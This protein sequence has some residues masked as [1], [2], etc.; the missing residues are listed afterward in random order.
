MINRKNW[1]IFCRV[2]D[3]FG[4][5]GVCW[6][7][8]R[9]LV[10]E[11]QKAVTLWVDDLDSFHAIWPEID[12]T[13]THQACAGVD[14][15]KWGSPLPNIEVMPEVVIEAF[16][17]DLPDNYVSAMRQT[18][19]LWLNLEYL[20][21]EPWVKGCHLNQSP[22]HG[23]RKTFFFPGFEPGTGGLLWDESLMQLDAGLATRAKRLLALAELGAEVDPRHLII[24]LFAYENAAL[25]ALLQALADRPKPTT[26][27]IPAG[28][29]LAGVE[30]WLDASLKPGD[31]I[32][33]GQLTIA[34]LPFLTQIQYD[35]LLAASDLNFVRGE[36]SFVRCQMLAK[37]FMWHIYPQEEAAHLLKLEA[38]L[39]LF[40]RDADPALS[41]A[42]RAAHGLWNQPGTNSTVVWSDWLDQLPALNRHCI[43][44]RKQRMAQGDLASNIVQF[45]TNSV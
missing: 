42:V 45:C 21:A 29:V 28:R 33:S 12:T 32:C 37:P 43:I 24:S 10:Q 9:Q 5:I 15:C 30:H 27:L 13:S 2:V 7:L 3:N 34:V 4:D 36:D 11:H 41:H 6:R 14:I 35:H 38:F 44:W 31:N 26:L 39:D 16:G 18:R 25:P 1:H 8:A 23:L 20:S 40:L 22:V 17:C 19:P